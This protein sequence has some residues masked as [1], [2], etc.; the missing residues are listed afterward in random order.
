M[1][2]IS[3]ESWINKQFIAHRGFHNNKDVPE[4]S[5][6]AFQ[7]AYEQGFAIE[8]DVHIIRDGTLVVFHDDHLKRMTGVDKNLENCVFDEIANLKLGNTKEDIPLFEDVLKIIDGKVPLMIELKNSGKAGRLEKA[9]YEALKGYQGEYV[10]QS[11]NPFSV[12]WFKKNAK[13][14]IR[15]QLSGSYKDEKIN[16]IKKFLLKNLMLNII[17]KP[18]FVNYEIGYLDK[19]ILK[20]LK[21]KRIPIIAWTARDIDTFRLS[22]KKCNN[23]VFEGFFPEDIDWG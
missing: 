5:I 20:R 21:T 13:E 17:S 9:A 11:F 22:L 6:Y 16:F 7:Y 1:A 14:V 12:A 10:I 19:W 3:P 23:V 8:L 18:D 4:N 15:G 2:R